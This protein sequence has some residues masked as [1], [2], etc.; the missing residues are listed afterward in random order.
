MVPETGV[1]P[2]TFALR[3]S[4]TS[5]GKS[6]KSVKSGLLAVPTIGKYPLHVASAASRDTYQPDEMANSPR[7]LLLAYWPSDGHCPF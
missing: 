7:Y 4:A 5:L 6:W 1:E 2:A 3:K